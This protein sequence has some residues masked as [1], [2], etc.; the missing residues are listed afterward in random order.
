MYLLSQIDEGIDF[1]IQLFFQISD[2]CH[3]EHE[4]C[5]CLPHCLQMLTERWRRHTSH[6]QSEHLDLFHIALD[7]LIQSV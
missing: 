7:L 6:H 1:I 4:W 2:L 5:F 3:T